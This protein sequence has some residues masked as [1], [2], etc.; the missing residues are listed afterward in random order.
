VETVFTVENKERLRGK[1]VMLVDDVI[2]TGATL[3]SCASHLLKA[4]AASVAII[5]IAASLR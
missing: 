3:E 2:T 4:E 1:K 5:C